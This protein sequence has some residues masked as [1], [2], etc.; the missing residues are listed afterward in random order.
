MPLLFPITQFY[1]YISLAKIHEYIT[2]T[3]Y[4]IFFIIYKSGAF[5]QKLQFLEAQF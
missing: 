4:M 5:D 2:K 3:F 1:S